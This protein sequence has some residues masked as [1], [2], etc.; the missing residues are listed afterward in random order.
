L[1]PLFDSLS[2]GVAETVR[3]LVG[4]SFYFSEDTFDAI[5]IPVAFILESEAVSVKCRL[6]PG[7]R[8]DEKER[9][10]DE[11]F[12]AEFSKEHLGYRLISRRSKL[13]V[14][15]AVRI[16]INRSVQPVAFRAELDHGFVNRNV[17]RVG[18]AEGL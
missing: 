12:L 6:Q 4:S 13:H 3:E 7:R 1:Q 15:Q 16:G 17:I 18:T 8:I 14:Q 5:P 2:V 11:M 9:V 10:I